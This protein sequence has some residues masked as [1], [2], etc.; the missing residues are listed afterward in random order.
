MTVRKTALKVKILSALC[1]LSILFALL[2]A[3][4]LA[5]PTYHTGD[6]AV[7][8]NMIDNNGLHTDKAPEN[9]SSVPN[10]WNYFVTWDVDSGTPYRVKE[11]LIDG[12]NLSG[13]LDA[14]GLTN[15]QE[16]DCCMNQLSSLN[17][18]GLTN[19]KVLDFGENQLL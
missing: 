18:R 2:P 14:R 13:A 10:E 19:L 3:T 16:L 17:V 12:M 1:V 15:L 4:A 6:I 7:I 5:D 8:N 9:G 11:L